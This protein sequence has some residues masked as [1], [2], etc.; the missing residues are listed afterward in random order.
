MSGSEVSPYVQAL[1]AALDS[2]PEPL[3]KVARE[4]AEQIDGLALFALAEG[5]LKN[6]PNEHRKLMQARDFLHLVAELFDGKP[7]PQ[8]PAAPF[9]PALPTKA[10][11]IGRRRGP[12]I[13]AE[14]H[15][16]HYEAA[17]IV[18]RARGNGRLEKEAVAFAKQ[19]TGL[20]ERSIRNGVK[21]RTELIVWAQNSNKFRQ[22]LDGWENHSPKEIGELLVNIKNISLLMGN[23][24]TDSC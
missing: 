5:R 12:E 6:R 22:S 21:C 7:R 3:G 1:E 18:F 17:E 16:R 4:I 20:S 23:R 13:N 19:K 15:A 9:A 8:T 24:G 11:L 2:K 14:G 10:C